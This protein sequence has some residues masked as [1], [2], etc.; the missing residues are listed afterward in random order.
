VKALDFIGDAVLRALREG[1]EREVLP[2]TGEG[3]GVGFRTGHLARNLVRG[4]ISGD[5]RSA[6]C[7]ISAPVDR[8]GWLEA[9]AREGNDWMAVDGHIGEVIQVALDEYSRRALEVEQPR[10]QRGPK[11]SGEA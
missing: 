7:V 2:N 1:F 11:R 5:H 9:Q 6:R 10:P 8:Q 4:P 3:V